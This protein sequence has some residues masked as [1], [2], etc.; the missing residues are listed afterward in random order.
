MSGKY[1]VR[2]RNKRG[3]TESSADLVVTLLGKYRLDCSYNHMVLCVEK[4]FLLIL[5][6]YCSIDIDLIVHITTW[7]HVYKRVLTLLDKCGPDII[8]MQFYV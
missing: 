2:A 1:T 7:F 8:N 4:S 6:L 5:L 3:V